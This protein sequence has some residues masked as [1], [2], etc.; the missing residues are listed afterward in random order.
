[1]RLDTLPHCYTPLLL[2]ESTGIRHCAPLLDTSTATGIQRDLT[3]RPIIRHL[4]SY[5]N[6]MRLDTLPL[7]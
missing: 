3:P 6:P 1:M 2:P 7:C 4:Y 5:R